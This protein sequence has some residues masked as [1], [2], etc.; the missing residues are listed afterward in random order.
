MT[1]A[2]LNARESLAGAM[3]KATHL[4]PEPELSKL[5]GAGTVFMCVTTKT[6]ESADIA[7]A[8]ASLLDSVREQVNSVEMRLLAAYPTHASI[9]IND[10]GG[11]TIFAR[12]A[13][14]WDEKR[15]AP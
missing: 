5:Q 14:V 15:S 4:I 1:D 3:P 8:V 6:Q 13:G 12:Y 2:E 11:S 7:K 9:T 10:S